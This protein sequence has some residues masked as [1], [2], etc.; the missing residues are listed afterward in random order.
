M[1]SLSTTVITAAQA[2]ELLH[3][4]PED[5]QRV[6][7]AAGQAAET[8][9][10]Y[11]LGAV[12]D[13]YVGM[14]RDQ[15]KQRELGCSQLQIAQHLD[16][17]DRRLR[18]LLTEWGIDHRTETLSAMRVRYIRKLR[19][20]AAGRASAGDLDLAQERA[21]L[22]RE[23]RIRIALQNAV[24]RREYAPIT[25]LTDVLAMANASIVS[26]L[27]QLDSRIAQ[28]APDL[29]EATR[30]AMLNTIAAARNECVRTTASLDINQPVSTEDDET[31]ETGGLLEDG[32]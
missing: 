23:Q 15:V 22:A 20:E 5:L 21:A 4:Q 16:I 30:L 31:D 9:A 10:A 14:L 25:A 12:I 8:D 7:M 1:D 27:D 26:M 18:E 3:L 28:T 29:P 2:G 17:S 6:L 24:A 32:P 11:T 19:E 13:A